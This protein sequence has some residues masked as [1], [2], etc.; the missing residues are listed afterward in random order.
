M[1]KHWNQLPRKVME[2]SSVEI[3]KT[4]LDIALSNLLFV[5]MFWAGGWTTSSPEVPTSAT[6]CDSVHGLFDREESRRRKGGTR[7]AKMWVQEKKKK[8]KRQ[9]MKSAGEQKRE[10]SC[11]VHSLVIVDSCWWWSS[12]PADW[13]SPQYRKGPSWTLLLESPSGPWL[14]DLG[15]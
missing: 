11:D 13:S 10:G 2:S 12:W 9:G 14:K 8:K 4:R 15:W 1:I 6:R 7:V 5:T 3:I